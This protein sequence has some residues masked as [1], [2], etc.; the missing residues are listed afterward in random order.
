LPTEVQVLIALNNHAN[1]LSRLSGTALTEL[2]AM[3][4]LPLIVFPSVGMI[5]IS[6][7]SL[8][9]ANLSLKLTQ[10]HSP[11]FA[12]LMMALNQAVTNFVKELQCYLRS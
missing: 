5:V 7:V 8:V 3:Y 11:L 6:S 2:N 9:E 12:L 10:L 4:G 1:L